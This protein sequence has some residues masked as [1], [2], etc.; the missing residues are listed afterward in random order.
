M[1]RC[2]RKEQYYRGCRH[3]VSEY[4]HCGGDHPDDDTHNDACNKTPGIPPGTTE[5]PPGLP[6][7]C[8]SFCSAK[9]LGWYCCQC[10][11][12]SGIVKGYLMGD[13]TTLVHDTNEVGQYH[14]WCEYCTEAV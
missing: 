5:R 14:V 7:Y 1:P 8:T 4:T 11:T 12:G 10:P 6:G 13:S 2:H 9:S 3:T